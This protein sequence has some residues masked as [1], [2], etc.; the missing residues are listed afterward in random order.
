ML[1]HV[2][3][4]LHAV[5]VHA[6]GQKK[7]FKPGKGKRS[8]HQRDDLANANIWDD[9]GDEL[10]EGRERDWIDQLQQL[11]ARS[12]AHLT[13]VRMPQMHVD[14]VCWCGLLCGLV[15]GSGLQ[16]MICTHADMLQCVCAM[17]R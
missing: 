14:G 5:L 13:H 10:E 8:K 3:S 11:Q 12:G 15:G 4:V 9:A 17:F 16:R 1:Q 7:F 2:G 6:V